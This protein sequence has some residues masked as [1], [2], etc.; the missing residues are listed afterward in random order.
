MSWELVKHYRGCIQYR[1]VVVSFVE[2]GFSRNLVFENG[3]NF[4]QLK[5]DLDKGPAQK[6][7]AK[8]NVDLTCPGFGLLT[9]K[10]SLQRASVQYKDA[11]Q[12]YSAL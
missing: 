2:V 5:I 12:A 8:L 9:F 6:S 7:T 10:Q 3:Q 1:G 4:L 11:D